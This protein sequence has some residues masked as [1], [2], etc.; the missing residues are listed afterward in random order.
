MG[1][2]QDLLKHQMNIMPDG[3]SMTL[4]VL[5]PI[6][7]DESTEYEVI[8]FETRGT[9]AA[10]RKHNCVHHIEML[11]NGTPLGPG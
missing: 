1:G 4:Q 7:L 6:P 2:G 9:K 11:N 8:R 3:S 10:D 5:K